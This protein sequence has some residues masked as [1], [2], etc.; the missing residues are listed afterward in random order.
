VRWKI[1]INAIDFGNTLFI[2]NDIAKSHFPG[3]RICTEQQNDDLREC[4]P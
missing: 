1:A 3:P 2:T 4:F